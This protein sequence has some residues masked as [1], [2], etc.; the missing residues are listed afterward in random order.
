MEVFA[1]L[2]DSAAYWVLVDA[3]LRII[4]ACV[5]AFAVVVTA[6]VCLW[7]CAVAIQAIRDNSTQPGSHKGRGR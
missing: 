3:R 5:G 7:M 2:V 1:P 4:W 6:C